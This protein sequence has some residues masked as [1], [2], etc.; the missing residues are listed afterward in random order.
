MNNEI[1]KNMKQLVK[2]S[3]DTMN[4]LCAI[5]M[6]ISKQIAEQNMAFVNLGI[7]CITSQIKINEKSNDYKE[8][9]NKQADLLNE[10]NEKVQG[11]TRNA[12]DIMSE[13]KEE[14]TAWVEKGVQEA[15][16]ITPFNKKSA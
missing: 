10:T 8:V 15:S 9:L 2:S 11:L 5:N 6:R 4:N 13:T 16:S 12:I 1:V 14:V 7:G 3:C